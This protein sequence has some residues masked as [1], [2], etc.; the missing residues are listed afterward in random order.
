MGITDE[1]KFES[2]RYRVG[3]LAA[4]A[5]KA[6]D[7]FLDI[8]NGSIL[9][10]FLR[11]LCHVHADIV[12]GNRIETALAE[13]KCE[14]TSIMEAKKVQSWPAVGKAWSDVIKVT[15]ATTLSL[16]AWSAR[17]TDKSDRKALKDFA[18]SIGSLPDPSGW[19]SPVKCPLYDC[20]HLID[21]PMV[22]EGVPAIWKEVRGGIDERR[23][24][25]KKTWQAMVQA[26]R[27][28]K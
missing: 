22:R 17:V 18:R 7:V 5:T 10:S 23:G 25:L 19:S 11:E 14:I 28:V 6:D 8:V 2:K 4:I 9:T 27:D 26:A 16:K 24:E 15:S 21:M 20:P 12:K 1:E 3:V 13:L